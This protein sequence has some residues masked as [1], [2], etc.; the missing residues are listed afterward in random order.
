MTSLTL[1][2]PVCQAS[3]PVEAGLQDV[4]ARQALLAAAHLWPVELQ[5]GL[6]TYLGLFRPPQRALAWGK[7]A[8]LLTALVELIRTGTVTRHRESRPASLAQWAAGV[9]E[10][11]KMRDAG[12]LTLPLTSH[13]LLAEIVHRQAGQA[14]AQDDAS[15]KPLHPSHRPVGVG[16]PVA[17]G[18][19]GAGQV[20][21][22]QVGAGLPAS[23]A[24]PASR[25]PHSRQAGLT[26][27]GH[28]TAA[29]R[30]R[31]TPSPTP[32]TPPTTTS[33]PDH[34]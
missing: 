20:G 21:A 30:R 23:A 28:L 18:Q 29:L 12:T 4:A 5:P 2:C 16:V 25:A 33:D 32:G 11:L 1:V 17:A 27:V 9:D 8:R 31:T 34:E 19:V 24:A 7:V 6:L 13:G 14:R 22:G 26:A 3:Y 15:R 10:I